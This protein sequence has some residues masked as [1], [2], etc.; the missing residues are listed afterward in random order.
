MQARVGEKVWNSQRPNTDWGQESIQSSRESRPASGWG[1]LQVQGNLRSGGFHS[2]IWG[3]GWLGSGDKARAH[4]H[5]GPQSKDK[6]R[7]KLSS[8]PTL[9]KRSHA[10]HHTDRQ[11]KWITSD[12][13][14]EWKG[15]NIPWESTVTRYSSL[16]FAIQFVL[17]VWS[18]IPQ[19]VNLASSS[20][21]RVRLAALINKPCNINGLTQPMFISCLYH[22]QLPENRSWRWGAL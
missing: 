17:P 10:S 5:R 2:L 7:N 20:I 11:G 6:Q 21:F 16:R 3:W 9:S 13:G 18:E 8:L 15:Q 4:P 22:I 19:A 12:L 1:H 14:I